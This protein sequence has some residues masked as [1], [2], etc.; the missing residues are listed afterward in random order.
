MLLN[1]E[2]AE[3]VKTHIGYIEIQPNSCCT[4]KYLDMEYDMDTLE[5]QFVCKLVSGIGN[6]PVKS[7]GICNYFSRKRSV[8]TL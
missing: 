7:Y 6:M 5:N 4:C 1:Q 2:F 3:K 8:E